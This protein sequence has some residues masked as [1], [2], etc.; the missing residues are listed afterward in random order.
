PPDY[1]GLGLSPGLHPFMH[2]ASETTASLDM[3][4]AAATVTSRRGL[5]LSGKVFITGFSQGGHST[6]ATGRAIQQRPGPWKVTA[7]APIAGPYDLAGAEFPAMF[8]PARIEPHHASAYL[9]YIL[10]AWNKLYHLYS[11]PRQVY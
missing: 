10:T 1:L 5:H 9:A 11:D 2:A 4:T 6:M 3:L 8:D 7:L